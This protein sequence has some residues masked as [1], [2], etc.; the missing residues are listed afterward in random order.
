MLTKNVLLMAILLSLS[1]CSEAESNLLKFHDKI[2]FQLPLGSKVLTYVAMSEQQKT[3]GL[4]GVQDK[5]FSDSQAMIFFYS[6]DGVRHF[7]MPNTYF[8]LE[9][10]FLD[11]DFKVL[12]VERDVPHH[13]GLIEPPKIFRTKGHFTRYVLEMR[14]SSSLAKKLMPGDVLK[15]V[16]GSFP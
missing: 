13:P 11:K 12:S 10:F 3:Q 8:D 1:S 15:L 5:D 14:S 4:S 7:W 16:K 2:T 9:I 6:Q